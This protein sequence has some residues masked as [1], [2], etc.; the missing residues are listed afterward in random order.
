M[1]SSHSSG[2]FCGSS[3]A[4]DRRLHFLCT[5]QTHAPQVLD[6]KLAKRIARY[7]KR[8]AALNLEMA[9]TKMTR[10]ALQLEAYSDADFATDK[11]DR[12]ASQ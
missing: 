10:D 8:T 11:A 7:L 5:S 3:G 2:G 4:R 9:P 1:H 12:R 6:W